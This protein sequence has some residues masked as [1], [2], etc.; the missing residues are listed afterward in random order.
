MDRG[1]GGSR[2]RWIDDEGRAG[3]GE[4]RLAKRKRGSKLIP[5]E[6]AMRFLSSVVL[7]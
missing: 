6:K 3:E 1:G 5:G 7:S 4:V 2:E